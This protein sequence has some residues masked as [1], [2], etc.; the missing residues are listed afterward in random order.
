MLPKT[1][2]LSSCVVALP[3]QRHRRL[4]FAHLARG[5]VRVFDA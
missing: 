2:I 1:L 4:V 3:S 5:I